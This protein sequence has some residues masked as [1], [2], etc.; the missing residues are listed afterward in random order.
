MC[1]EAYCIA[2]LATEREEGFIATL[3]WFMGDAGGI[4]TCTGILGGGDGDTRD[5]DVGDHGL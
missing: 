2:V 1:V 5:E 4:G 3:A